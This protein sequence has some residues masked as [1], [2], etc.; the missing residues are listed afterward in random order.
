MDDLILTTS[1]PSLLQTITTQ[2]QSFFAI[3]DLGPLHYFLGIQ[4]QFTDSGLI[5]Y[6]TNYVQDLL[7]KLCFQHL[8]FALSPMVSS[9]RLSLHDGHPMDNPQLY[10]RH[11]APCNMYCILDLI[12]LLPSIT[13]VNSTNTPPIFIGKLSSV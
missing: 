2:L 12:V 10:R 3:K 11:W 7:T 1:N 9:K 6:Q 13:L 5:L 4:A 8:K